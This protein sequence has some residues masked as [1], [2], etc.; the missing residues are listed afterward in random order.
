MP[1]QPSTN[2]IDS[3]DVS[4]GGLLQQSSMKPFDL[5]SLTELIDFEGD[6]VYTVF[7]GTVD[8]AGVEASFRM[9]TGGDESAKRLLGCVFIAAMPAMG[10]DEVIVNLKDAYGFYSEPLEAAL[11]PVGLE[12]GAATLLPPAERPELFI[13]EE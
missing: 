7:E 9:L 10:L 5:Q 11:L 3:L 4:S 12:R 1:W 13:S 2:F 8:S 6:P